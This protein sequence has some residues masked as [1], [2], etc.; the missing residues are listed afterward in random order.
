[1]MAPVLFGAPPESSDAAS[2]SGDVVEDSEGADSSVGS[3]VSAVDD[4]DS[5][6]DDSDDSVVRV[7]DFEVG[8][9]KMVCVRAVAPHAM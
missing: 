8:L 2:G 3:E 1:M 5:D 6:S 4:S 9:G 7:S